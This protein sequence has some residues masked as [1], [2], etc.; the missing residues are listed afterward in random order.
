MKSYYENE[1][2][3]I[4]KKA[5]TI[6][7]RLFD[8]DGNETKYLDINTESL[9]ALEGFLKDIRQVLVDRSKGRD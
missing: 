1:L 8:Y 5:K 4:N 2:E 6:S 3:K 7:V 9:E